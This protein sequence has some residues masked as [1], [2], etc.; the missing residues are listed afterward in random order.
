MPGAGAA[1]HACNMPQS[2]DAEGSPSPIDRRFKPQSSGSGPLLC[3]SEIEIARNVCQ[4]LS[5]VGRGA[6]RREAA[7]GFLP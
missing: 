4:L 3:L 6:W 1:N 2:K 7:N 5:T